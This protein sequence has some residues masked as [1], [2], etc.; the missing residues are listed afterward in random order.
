MHFAFDLGN[1]GVTTIVELLMLICTDFG[2]CGTNIYRRVVRVQK[3]PTVIAAQIKF[4]L[5]NSLKTQ[6][7]VS[8]NNHSVDDKRWVSSN[9]Y[10]VPSVR[11]FI[12]Y[13]VCIGVIN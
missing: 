4:S 7:E 12:I 10:S 8:A 2:A 13:F 3:K 11:F 5:T 6:T 1:L 9:W